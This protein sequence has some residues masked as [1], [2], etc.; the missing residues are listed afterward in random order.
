VVY[1]FPINPESVLSTIKPEGVNTMPPQEVKEIL[2][3]LSQAE[4]EEERLA[5][6]DRAIAILQTLPEAERQE[7]ANNEFGKHKEF[8]ENRI[9][10]QPK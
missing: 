7:I 3:K 9:A 10:Q 1:D 8:I 5:L 4:T 2:Q 6:A